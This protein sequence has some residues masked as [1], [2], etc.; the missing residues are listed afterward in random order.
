[1]GALLLFYS[2]GLP[3]LHAIY[4]PGVSGSKRQGMENSTRE[5]L[6]NTARV[7]K[8]PLE[9]VEPCFAHARER[10]GQFRGKRQSSS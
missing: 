4:A 10:F 3:F 1:V 5:L 6:A 8:M 2:F 7:R 9:I